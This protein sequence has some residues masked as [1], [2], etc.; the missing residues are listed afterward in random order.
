MVCFVFIR[1]AE[2]ILSF[3][4]CSALM[5]TNKMVTCCSEEMKPV[6]VPLCKGLDNLLRGA[7]VNV[8]LDARLLL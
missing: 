5:A 3:Y 2:C 7:R 1:A 4:S 8:T 6:A